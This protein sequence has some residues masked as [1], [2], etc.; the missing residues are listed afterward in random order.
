MR[1]RIGTSRCDKWLTVSET[2]GSGECTNE[3]RLYIRMVGGGTE[4]VELQDEDRFVS[5]IVKTNICYSEGDR[6]VGWFRE[7]LHGIISVTR[8]RSGCFITKYLVPLHITCEN[9]FQQR[10]QQSTTE[11][12]T[13]FV[14]AV[15]TSSKSVTANAAPISMYKIFCLLNMY[16]FAKLLS[17]PVCYL[18]FVVLHTF[19]YLKLM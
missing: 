13:T 11:A 17:S 18:I 5:S 8:S 7:Y 12:R 2:R 10:K 19:V 1:K 15:T 6:F 9:F 14:V 3:Y 16:T 4:M